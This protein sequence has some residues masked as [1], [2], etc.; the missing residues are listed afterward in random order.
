MTGDGASFGARIRSRDDIHVIAALTA[1]TAWAIGP[2]FTKSM[3]VGVPS[4]VLY[5]ITIGTPVMIAMSYRFGDGLSIPLLK[6]TALPGLLFGSSMLAGFAGIRMTSVANATSSS[7]LAVHFGNGSSAFTF[8]NA[9]W[10]TF[11]ATNETTTFGVNTVT[12]DFTGTFTPGT[13]FGGKTTNTADAI[14]TFNQ[15]NGAGHA[16]SG[17]MTLT[18]P[19]LTSA[20]EIDANVFV[21]AF[22]LLF[23]SVA[24][25]FGRK[26]AGAV[27]A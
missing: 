7:P 16:V 5:R 22:V 18:S 11:T 2:L 1:I 8:G 23:G 10:G 19:Q 4:I 20:P 6:K 21:T 3:S 14:F 25:M 9:N 24:I 17:S 12:I 26:K 15:V 13:L 27:G